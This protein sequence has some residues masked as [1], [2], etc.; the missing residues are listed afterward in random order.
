MNVHLHPEPE[1]RMCRAITAL[2][3]ISITLCLSKHTDSSSTKTL[4]N[5]T[6]LPNSKL[7]HFFLVCHPGSFISIYVGHLK[8]NAQNAI[9]TE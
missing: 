5:T 1:L 4:N 9:L 7:I 2:P 8:R 6:V 3:Y